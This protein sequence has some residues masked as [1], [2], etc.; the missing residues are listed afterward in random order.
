MYVQLQCKAHWPAL[1]YKTERQGVPYHHDNGLSPGEGRVK[2]LNVGQESVVVHVLLGGVRAT[3]V[4][5][6][7]GAQDDRSEL[8]T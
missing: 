5:S 4:S 6:A 8:F 1:S 2:Q 7:N 3:G